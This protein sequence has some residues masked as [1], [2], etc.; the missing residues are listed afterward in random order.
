MKDLTGAIKLTLV[1]LIVI[2]LFVLI[3]LFAPETLKIL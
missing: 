2:G 3:F 1:F